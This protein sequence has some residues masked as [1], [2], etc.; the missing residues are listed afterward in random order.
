MLNVEFEFWTPWG[1]P[2]D[3]FPGDCSTRLRELCL[4]RAE[5]TGPFCGWSSKP[6]ESFKKC[7]K[8]KVTLETEEA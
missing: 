3:C 2:K 5:K 1:L 8:V 4:K 7:R 6:K